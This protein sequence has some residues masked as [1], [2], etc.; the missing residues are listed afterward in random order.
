MKEYQITLDY[1]GIE[2]E[3][4]LFNRIQLRSKTRAVNTAYREL[5][6]NFSHKEAIGL[7]ARIWV[8][9]EEDIEELLEVA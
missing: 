7:I 2:G 6:K 4:D 1:T 3:E 8:E 5:L 9:K